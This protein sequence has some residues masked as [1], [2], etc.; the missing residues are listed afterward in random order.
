MAFF[1]AVDAGGTKTDF[2]LAD[3]QHELARARSGSIKRMRVDAATA[4][5]N[6][7]QALSD[8]TTQ[9][10]V[11]M[12][13]I[14]CTCVGVAGES[15][16]LVA[17]WIREEF[18]THVSGELLLLGDVEIALDAA[19][20]GASGVLVLAGTGSN[21]AGRSADGAVTTAGG[22]GPA[23]SDQGSGH[24]IGS[25]ALRAIF[26]ALDEEK[27]TILLNAVMRLWEL[28]SISDL[29]DYANRRPSPDFSRLAEIVLSCAQQGDAVAL[30]VLHHEGRALAHLASLVIRRLQ[31]SGPELGWAPP[32]AFAGS[33]LAKIAP[34]RETLIETLQREFPALVAMPGVVD[35]LLGAL[36]RARTY[37]PYLETTGK[38]GLELRA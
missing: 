24:R 13:A 35:P 14:A 1:L 27:P 4:Q 21:V 38:D 17:D 34:V 22:W 15:V 7:E 5:R 31:R 16:P 33:I 20:P 25:E 26:L 11:S 10:G 30:S 18:A 36:W 8:L 3:E 2:V 9:T 28:D 19:F 23:L 29:V 6:L 32:V 12:D 37:Q